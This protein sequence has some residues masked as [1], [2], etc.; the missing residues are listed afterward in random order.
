[1]EHFAQADTPDGLSYSGLATALDG[2]AVYPHS[3]DL[4]LNAQVSPPKGIGHRAIM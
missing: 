2:L 4:P 1:M 3:N